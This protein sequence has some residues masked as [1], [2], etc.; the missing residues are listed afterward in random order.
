MRNIFLY[1]R[2][3]HVIVVPRG[4][5][6]D[7]NSYDASP[8]LIVPANPTDIAA[9]I[10]EGLQI[11]EER[12]RQPAD[13]VTA[14]RSTGVG[15]ELFKKLQVR[16]WRQFYNGASLCSLL[17]RPD[18]R[19]LLEWVP[20]KPGRSWTSKVYYPGTPLAGVTDLGSHVLE[21]LQLLPKMTV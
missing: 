8:T 2:N 19:F 10:E 20:A 4:L 1:L 15:S 17:E 5:L 9:A 6:T 16:S 7:G 12:T 14:P 18:G 11:S 21:V 13:P 3:G